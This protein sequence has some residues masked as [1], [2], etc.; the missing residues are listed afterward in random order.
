MLNK[1]FESSW[2]WRFVSLLSRPLEMPE[3]DWVGGELSASAIAF[4]SS[5]P[6]RV[7]SPSMSMNA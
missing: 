3:E 5:A 6:A 7:G 4:S 1:V 2:R